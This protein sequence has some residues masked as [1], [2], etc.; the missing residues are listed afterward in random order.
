MVEG[1]LV[2]SSSG[3]FA[4]PQKGVSIGSGDSLEN[5]IGEIMKKLLYDIEFVAS[6]ASVEYSM[7]ID[8]RKQ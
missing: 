1:F 8:G 6:G 7:Y 4:C 5:K 2:I 3:F